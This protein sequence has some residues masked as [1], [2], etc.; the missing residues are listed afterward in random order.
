MRRRIEVFKGFV[1]TS[2]FLLDPL[3]SSLPLPTMEIAAKTPR[4]KVTQKCLLKKIPWC[5]CDF[6]A[7]KKPVAKKIN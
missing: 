6:V 2:F 7:K 3:F 4:H 1:N 5:L